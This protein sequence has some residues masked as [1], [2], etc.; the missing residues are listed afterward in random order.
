MTFSRPS[1]NTSFTTPYTYGSLIPSTWF[2]YVD[3]AIPNAL[4]KTGDTISGGSTTITFDGSIISLIN[5]AEITLDP[6]SEIITAG[7]INSSGQ[8]LVGGNITIQI[9]GTADWDG[10]MTFDT[11]STSYY[12]PSS[13]I[14]GLVTIPNAKSLSLN[15]DGT[16]TFYINA[17]TKISANVSF[18]GNWQGNFGVYTI[19]DG[20]LNVG[21]STSAG[22][23]SAVIQNYSTFETI[24]GSTSIFGGSITINGATVLNNLVMLNGGMQVANASTVVVLSG[25]EINVADGASLVT[26]GSSATTLNGPV[27]F[28]GTTTGGFGS[29]LS[30]VSGSIFKAAGSVVLTGS[31]GGATAL[32]VNWVSSQ[33]TF[34]GG[35][36]DTQTL[37]A[38]QQGS[39]YV[40][41]GSSTI[42]G[43]CIL[44]FGGVGP[45]VPGNPVPV[46]FVDL[47]A[48]Q[49]D[50][51]GYTITFR[52]GGSGGK[53]YTFSSSTSPTLVTVSCPS[54]TTVAVDF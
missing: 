28:Y 14:T 32:P 48:C 42:N 9:G 54:P 51:N 27:T 8:I 26:Q 3:Q 53:T 52:N 18:N 4:D 47:S 1:T 30:M 23:A 11:A 39:P 45:A 34:T 33:I 6:Y 2:D 17:P 36:G 13:L 16:G 7:T 35:G 43:N 19:F 46:F 37:A 29:T 24:S 38:S 50:L 10:Y 49:S 20:S 12:A 21:D 22:G 15:A 31:V 41:C 44:D 5:G 25:S 40:L